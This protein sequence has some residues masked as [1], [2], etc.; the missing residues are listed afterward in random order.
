[1]TPSHPCHYTARPSGSARPDENIDMLLQ[2]HNLL[3][4]FVCRASILGE[5]LPEN[6]RGQGLDRLLS[7]KTEDSQIAEFNTQRCIQ[8]MSILWDNA[9]SHLPTTPNRVSPFHKYCQDVIGLG[10]GV[11]HTPPY[12]A[13]CNPVELFFSYVKRYVRKLRVAKNFILII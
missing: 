1:M 10:G 11:V 8:N 12:S 3:L 7:N 9:P 6:D 4:G 2:H 13:W 5:N